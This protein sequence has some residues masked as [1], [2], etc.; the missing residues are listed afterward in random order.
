MNT[1]Q[2][3]LTEA[4]RH[5]GDIVRLAFEHGPGQPAVVVAD[6]QTAL[7]RLLSE[8]YR[9]ALPHADWIHFDETPPEQIL[10]Q[11]QSLPR[12]ALVVLVQ[13]GNFRL[14]AYRIRVELFKQGLKV[15]EHPHLKR[16]Q[17]GDEERRYLASLAYDPAYIRGTGQALKACI[18][19]A[20]QALLDSGGA[21]LRVE[22]A[23][24]EA[25]LNIGDY[26][27]M[28]NAGGQ[29]PIGEVFTEARDLESV[30]GCVRIAHFGDASFTVN[31]PPE[32]IVL[33]VE[34]GRVVR[35]E[36]STPAFEDVLANIRADEGQIWVRELGFG[37]N[38]AFSL[39][40][41]V[42]DVGTYERVCGVHLSLGA[43]HGSYSKPQISRSAARH[44]VD[45]FPATHQFLLDETVVF[46]DGR[47]QV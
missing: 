13:S 4:T 32:P 22:G 14:G 2:S 39:A 7:A 18:D 36:H 6:Q 47:W 34:A 11:L 20:Q 9:R 5:V 27:N 35:T 30:H 40:E 26:R 12:G 41:T 45:V 31:T 37:L 3:S 15:I 38:R 1:L 17:A 16:M 21:Q 29:F 44:H 33:H 23:L 43:K 24:E 8:A 25:K 19:R 10:R 28:N 46:A 42:R